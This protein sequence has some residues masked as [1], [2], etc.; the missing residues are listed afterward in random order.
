VKIIST[1]PLSHVVTELGEL[2]PGSPGPGHYRWAKCAK[3]RIGCFFQHEGMCKAEEQ[4][5][6][7]NFLYDCIYGVLRAD[8]PISGKSVKLK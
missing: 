4:R 6:H 2:N 1:S 8:S 7:E 3:Q 5:A